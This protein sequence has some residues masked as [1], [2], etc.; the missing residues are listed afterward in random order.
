MFEIPRE[1]KGNRLFLS[2][3]SEKYMKKARTSKTKYIVVHGGT[4]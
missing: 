1:K 4:A 2:I 3:F